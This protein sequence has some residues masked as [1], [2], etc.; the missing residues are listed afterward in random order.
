VAAGKYK[1]DI[2]MERDCQKGFT[3]YLYL[4]RVAPKTRRA[5]L[6][7]VK[8]LTAYFK[9]PADQLTNDQIQDYL[10]YCIK[11]KKLAWAS[12][13]VIFSGLK[14]FYHGFLG[15]D[16]T[17]FSIPPRPR[18]HQLP[19]LLSRDEVSRILNTPDN[20]KH[21][22]LLAIIY[23]SGLRVSEAVRL[24]AEHID[25][26]KMMIRIEQSKGRKDRYTI[27]SKSCLLLLREYWRMYQPGKWLFFTKDKNNPMPSE[28]AQKVYSL[29][30]HKAG[31]T[32]G[33]GIHT[34]RHC[35]ASHA[36]EQGVQLFIIKR[37]LGHSSIKTTCIYL[38]ASP[39]MLL[40]VS[41]PLDSLM[42]EDRP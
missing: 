38:H 41:S 35:F 29:A 34:L 5:Y 24:R 40:N 16:N 3:S 28:T 27:L 21:R 15:R 19:M 26:K 12:C 37:W 33:R 8:G 11:E 32:K 7:P 14:K 17:G 4:Q 23:G 25:S 39:E 18:S 10:L 2:A 36:L 31:V 9:Q 42:K 22:A 13:N 6:Q 1:G 20:L 30:K